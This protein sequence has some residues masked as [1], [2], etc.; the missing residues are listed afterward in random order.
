[1][2]SDPT[3]VPKED[4]LAVAEAVAAAAK[5]LPGFVSY[6]S[7]VDWETGAGVAIST[8]QD[9]E[10]ANFSRDDLGNVMSRIASLGIRLEPPAFYE[11]TATA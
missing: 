6:Q 3:Q 2:R 5:A 11:I 10:S 4:L 8:W 9:K 1:L 7:G